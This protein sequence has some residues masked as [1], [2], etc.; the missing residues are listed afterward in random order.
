MKERYYI[1]GTGNMTKYLQPYIS[2][3]M[4]QKEFIGYIDNDSTKTGTNF[5]GM[6]VFSPVVLESDKDCY[7]LILAMAYEEIHKQIDENYPWMQKRIFDLTIF[8]KHR[9]LNR[10]RKSRLDDT[11]IEE[12]LKYLEHND[13][14]I[15]NYSFT[16]KYK[17]LEISVEYDADKKL[18]F[19]LHEGKRLYFSK[20]YKTRETVAA[21][22]RSILIEQDEQ[23]PHCYLVDTFQIEKG[24]IAVDAGAAEGNFALS[25]IERV[26][27]I[28]IFEPD[29]EWQEALACTF[30]P[31]R[32]KV[33]L[34]N[35]LIS[36][37]EDEITTTLDATIKEDEINFIKVD[38]EG[39]EY[40][41]ICGAT[42]HLKKSKN[43]KCAICTYHQEFDY[44]I[45]EDTMTKLGFNTYPSKGYMWFPY[46][47]H[48]IYSLPTLR[49]G[50]LRAEKHER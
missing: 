29:E 8:I 39:E 37:Y 7:I 4:K 32:E 12:V 16:E 13:L 47:K 2:V 18:F 11:E 20:K 49:R 28:Y 1:W 35:K 48:I 50:L 30:A 25:V 22:Y 33:V 23:S 6:P 19:V 40:H 42:E 38:T 44:K 41:V 14:Q 9:L 43:I 24:A 26:K 34:V 3:V 46:D 31:Y 45:I 15:F 5:L 10:Y 27:K 17:K 36:D 21:Y